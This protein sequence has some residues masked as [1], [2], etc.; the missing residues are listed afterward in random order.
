MI[1]FRRLVERAPVSP[2]KMTTKMKM[3]GIRIKLKTASLNVAVAAAEAVELVTFIV[4]PDI[5]LLAA[6]CPAGRAAPDAA[7]SGARSPS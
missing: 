5:V 3:I 4:T 2:K 1:S 7:V 6:L